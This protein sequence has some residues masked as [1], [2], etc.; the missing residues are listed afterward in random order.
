MEVFGLLFSLLHL[1]L[2]LCMNRMQVICLSI[3]CFLG[4]LVGFAGIIV[5][6]ITKDGSGGLLALF[7]A[8]SFAM[9]AWMLQNVNM[10]PTDGQPWWQRRTITA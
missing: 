5:S 6:H 2:V 9:T 4:I 1:G 10:N 8:A 7:A 3:N